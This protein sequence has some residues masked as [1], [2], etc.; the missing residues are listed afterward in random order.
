MRNRMIRSAVAGLLCAVG[1]AAGAQATDFSIDTGTSVAGGYAWVIDPPGYLTGT[2]HDANTN[3]NENVYIGTIDLTGNLVNNPDAGLTSLQVFCIDIH[4]NL[5]RGTFTETSIANLENVHS[6]VNVHYSAQQVTDLTKFLAYVDVQ[7][8]GHITDAVTSAVAQLGV[9][10]II[11][12]ANDAN[13]HTADSNS[14]FW[15]SGL[16]TS[17]TSMADTWL[18]N[19]RSQSALNYT[20]HVLDP[21]AGNQTQAFVTHVPGDQIQ[22]GVPEPATWGMIV[23]GFGLLG[24]A[25]RRRKPEEMFA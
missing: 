14:S 9:W 2:I 13:W 22:L 17:V 19:S 10:E 15:V 7:T 23:V 5:A 8:H 25:L 4:D 24:A 20:L 21:D 16:D 6:D 11:S 12:E 3:T 1:F 18:A